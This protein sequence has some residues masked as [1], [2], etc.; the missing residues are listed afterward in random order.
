MLRFIIFFSLLVCALSPAPTLAQTSKKATSKKETVKKEKPI[1][2]VKAMEQAENRIDDNMVT[3]TNLVEALSNN[4]GQL[5]YLR[6]LCFTQDDQK[7]RKQASAMMTLEVPKDSA[8]RRQLIRAFNAGYYEQKERYTICSNTVAID[9]AVLAENGRRL[10]VML[11]D[12]YRE[13]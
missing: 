10:S 9:V 4:L 13:Q 8:R 2:P 6:T 12:P 3:M 1:D 5:H 11:S 7:W